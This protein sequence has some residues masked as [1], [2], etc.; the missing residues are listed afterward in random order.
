MK[1]LL[2]II[3][4]STLLFGKTGYLQQTIKSTK[5][6]ICI[7]KY[8]GSLYSINVGIKS[9]CKQSVNLDSILR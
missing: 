8:G 9:V 2:L 7:Y 5:N 6:T 4:L 3:G 1:K